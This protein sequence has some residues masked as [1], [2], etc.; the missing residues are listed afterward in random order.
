MD[1]RDG[2]WGLV[3]KTGAAFAVAG[4]PRP[5]PSGIPV[6]IKGNPECEAFQAAI[7]WTAARHLRPGSSRHFLAGKKGAG[8]ALRMMGEKTPAILSI[9]EA[10]Q[11][12]EN[13]ATSRMRR[14]FCARS[15]HCDGSWQST[16]GAGPPTFPPGR[17]L[18]VFD[19]F[20]REDWNSFRFTDRRWIVSVQTPGRAAV[21][22]ATRFGFGGPKRPGADGDPAAPFALFTPEDS[23]KG[24]YLIWPGRG[25]DIYDD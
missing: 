17:R 2:G 6:G 24:S 19:V 7:E 3:E 5:T 23:Q 1:R 15:I 25:G 4:K 22:R 13:G 20:P 10:R 8:I 14:D 16:S 12:R 9:P 18:F 21:A 11:F